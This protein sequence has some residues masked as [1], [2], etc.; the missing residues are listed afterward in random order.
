MK[1]RII[2]NIYLCILLLV[3]VSL[4]GCQ[5]KEQEF[6]FDK[7]AAI[8]IYNSKDEDVVQ[9]TDIE[10]VR[11]VLDSIS[12]I[13]WKVSKQDASN[14][15]AYQYRIR[16]FDKKGEHRQ[17]IMV[18]SEKRIDYNGKFWDAEEGELDLD[19]LKKLMKEK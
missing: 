7:V 15:D 5:K 3:T 14:Y 10:Q 12:G 4:T 13:V 1:N 11:K 9:I 19:L 8:K 2:C 18:C 17:N 6:D 16:C